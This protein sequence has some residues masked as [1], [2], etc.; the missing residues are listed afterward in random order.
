MKV[1]IFVSDEPSLLSTLALYRRTLRHLRP[2]QFYARAWFRLARPRPNLAPAPLLRK[3][4]AVWH[5]PAQRDCS[6]IEP[7][8]FHFVNVSGSLDEVG[9]DGAQREKLW[10]YN[11]HY[12]DDL[13]ARDFGARKDWHHAL[14][15][16]WVESNHPGSG[17]GWE[18][19]PTS[20]RIVNWVKWA[21]AGNELTAICLHSL[22]VQA[23]WLA[24][25]LEF[26]LLGNHLF[27]NAKALVFAGLFF[28]GEEAEGW[29][30]TGVRL[31]LRE[32]PEQ[33]L[34]DGGHFERSTMYHGLALEDMLDLCNVFACYGT[35]VS[36]RH[37]DCASQWR[38]AVNRM[39]VWHH[40]MC[41]PDGGIGFFNDAAFGIAPL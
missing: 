3:S 23:R 39:Q 6:L 15:A 36:S 16:N 24:K 21:L 35:A 5:W 18:P 13:N 19:Y 12:F 33:I 34:T 22:A 11:Q 4:A 31:L 17:S 29:L 30:S 27:A 28:K 26:H 37:R 9:W 14:L 38:I 32:V 8:T 41:H 7:T 40:A 10:R 2:V 1:G 25:R 20:L